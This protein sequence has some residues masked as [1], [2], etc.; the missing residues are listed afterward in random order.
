MADEEFRDDDIDLRI[1]TGLTARVNSQGK[2]I[3]GF[4]DPQGIYP[5]KEYENIATTNVA[6]RG[7]TINELL[8]HGGDVDISL[9]LTERLASQYPLNQVRETVS[10]HV[11]EID[12]TP[13]AERMLYRHRT[14]AGIE[15]RA[16]G[17]V[18]IN[19]VKNTV[20]ITGGDEKVIVEGDGEVTYHGNLKLN[21]TGDFDLKVGGDF[22]IITSGNKVEDI[23]GSYKQI[24]NRNH[25]TTVRKNRNAITTGTSTITNLGNYN[26]MV[27]GNQSNLVEGNA[28][29]FVSDTLTMTA[30][31]E[32]TLSSVNTNI[33][34]SS[35][36][37]I[38]DSG[39]IGGDNII[40]YFYNAYGVSS[41]FSA[42]VTAPTFH[43]D[44]QGTA[45]NAEN[46]NKAATAAL[47]A[48]AA[49][50]YNASNTATNTT[51]TVEPTTAIMTDYLDRSSKGYR[52]VQVDINDILRKK[53]DRSIDYGGVS[54]RPL[55]PPEVRSKLR[56]PKN[57]NNTTFVG[58]QI[59]EGKLS[60]TYIRK[61]P[62][63]IGR[64][65]KNQPT[66]IRGTRPIGNR[67][68]GLAKR[69]QTR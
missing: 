30:K 50:G 26:V 21:V 2:P 14:G 19:A 13:G 11:V 37:V 48:A 57:Y 38:G 29:L 40:N 63:A 3:S 6:A 15:L 41:T 55:S 61:T 69:V 62:F 60:P 52:R 35:L 8:T 22:N 46:A 68:K 24:V 27:K 18:I 51:A 9:E 43:G 12:D 1:T 34:A 58:S 36:T 53:V 16:D 5:K 23:H 39:T 32:V 56:D 17:S 20:H 42:G 25:D 47:G 49:G 10:G 54:S 31:N 4:E 59:S 64:I 65:I 67:S 45:L 7:F 33:A 66:P 44:L 28:N